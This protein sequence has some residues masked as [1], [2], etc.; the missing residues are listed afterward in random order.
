MWNLAHLV[1]I[2]ADASHAAAHGGGLTKREVVLAGSVVHEGRC[3]LVVLNKLDAL[4]DGAA[5]QQVP[6]RA[7]LC[8]CMRSWRVACTVVH[9]PKGLPCEG[10]LTGMRR[11]R[12]PCRAA[13]G[14]RAAPLT[15]GARGGGA[16]GAAA[17]GGNRHSLPG[18]QRADG[19]RRGAPDAVGAPG[20]RGMGQARAHRTPQPLAAA[21]GPASQPCS[22][23]STLSAGMAALCRTVRC[24]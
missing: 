21:G 16:A 17:A 13:R 3:L 14:E 5:R 8:L 7:L 9:D 12:C 11:H 6:P 22:A 19:R 20:V 10:C 23:G 24:F 2:V 1:V 4:P 18:H 15:G